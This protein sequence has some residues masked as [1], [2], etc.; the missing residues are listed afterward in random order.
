MIQILSE[1][2]P[3]ARKPYDCMACEWILNGGIDGEGFT[4]PELRALSKARKNKW[5]IVKGQK[6]IRQN[7]KLGDD[8]Y[9]FKAIPEIHDICLK[10]DLYEF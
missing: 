6:Y 5:Q 10:H 3:V 7:N 2:E 4:R 9:T 8:I 1:S